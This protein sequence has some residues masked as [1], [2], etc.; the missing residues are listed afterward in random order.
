MKIENKTQLRSGMVFDSGNGAYMIISD[1]RDTRDE[2][3]LEESRWMVIWFMN[4]KNNPCYPGL[5]FHG[6]TNNGSPRTLNA[7]FNWIGGDE[8]IYYINREV[9]TAVFK[10]AEIEP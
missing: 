5:S 8:M 1:D 6:R 3:W 10:E 7:M 4:T 2:D 9:L